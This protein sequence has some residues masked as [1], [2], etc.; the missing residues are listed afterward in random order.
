MS[1]FKIKAVVEKIESNYAYLQG[2]SEYSW[3]SPQG[4]VF[5]VLECEESPKL[6]EEIKINLKENEIFTE[7]LSQSLSHGI[8]FM[9]GLKKESIRGQ[10]SLTFLNVGGRSILHTRGILGACVSRLDTI[11]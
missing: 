8:P 6:V 1:D 3:V 4:K 11:R 5:S 2:T 10:V 7:C 9:F